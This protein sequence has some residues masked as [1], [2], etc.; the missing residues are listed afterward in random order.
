MNEQAAGTATVGPIVL[1]LIFIALQAVAVVFAFATFTDY[2]INFW[3][4]ALLTVGA[5]AFLSKLGG[6]R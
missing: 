4:A 1:G 5:N 3:E 6:E 2:E